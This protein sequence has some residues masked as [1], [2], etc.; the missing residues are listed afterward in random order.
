MTSRPRLERSTTSGERPVLDMLLGKEDDPDAQPA[1]QHPNHAD[2][3]QLRVRNSPSPPVPPRRPTTERRGPFTP[4]EEVQTLDVLANQPPDPDA[5]EAGALFDA[6]LGRTPD[7]DSDSDNDD[8]DLTRAPIV[9]GEGNR[10]EPDR[11]DWLLRHEVAD[12][13]GNDPNTIT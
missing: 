6:A 4:T 9:P 3:V 12:L 8:V 1:S 11:R 13:F 2:F 10:P 5:R 7:D